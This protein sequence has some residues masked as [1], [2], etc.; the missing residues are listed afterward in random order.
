MFM[1]S[2]NEHHIHIAIKCQVL[3][4]QRQNMVPALRLIRVNLGQRHQIT[5]EYSVISAMIEVR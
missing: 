3:W 1:Y 5:L 2:F 4:L